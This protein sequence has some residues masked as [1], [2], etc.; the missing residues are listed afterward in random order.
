MQEWIPRGNQSNKRGN[1]NIMK[2]LR[3]LLFAFRR[4]TH[5]APRK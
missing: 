2:V 4:K 1:G 3:I 5:L